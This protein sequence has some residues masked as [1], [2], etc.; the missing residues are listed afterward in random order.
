MDEPEHRASESAAAAAEPESPAAERPNPAAELLN[1]VAERLP[2]GVACYR[3]GYDL[4]GL[5]PGERCPECGLDA[6]ASW[7]VWDVRA[8]HRAYVE[9]LCAEAVLARRA[10]VLLAAAMGLLLAAVAAQVFA[11]IG[12]GR[13][14]AAIMLPIIAGVTLLFWAVLLVQLD[15]TVRRR[16]PLRAG[17]GD[18]RT[19]SDRGTRRGLRTGAWLAAAG[20]VLGGTGTAVFGMAASPLTTLVA[21]AA[22]IAVCVGVSMLILNIADAREQIAER[23]GRPRPAR[24]VGA[25]LVLPWAALPFGPAVLGV[26]DVLA[27]VVIAVLLI[28]LVG[29][30]VG[31]VWLSSS[32]ART[33]RAL[34]VDPA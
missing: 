22:L 10:A 32:L 31:T 28:A 1:P 29:S 20:V 25:V 5:A 8:C 4:V 16:P 3:C 6:A 19:R 18:E 17:E 21:Y 13:A 14:W 7:P 23:S 33:M 12:I 15:R 27:G 11:A 2:A 34:V 30:A 9:H 26:G 24:V